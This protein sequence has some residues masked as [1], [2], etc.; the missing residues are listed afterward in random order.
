MKTLLAALIVTLTAGAATPSFAE[1]RYVPATEFVRDHGRYHDDV[2]SERRIARMVFRS[3]F[4]EIE[5]IRLRG[6]RYVVRAV[7]PNGAVFRVVFDAYD[8]E[9]LARERIG[10]SRYDRRDYGRGPGVEFRFDLRG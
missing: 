2:L 7:R 10:W 6:D 4:A 1:T 8:G 5:N 9:I 3:G